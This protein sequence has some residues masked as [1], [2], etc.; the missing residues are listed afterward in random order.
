M[1]TTLYTHPDPSPAEAAMAARV[2]EAAA[3]REPIQIQGNST[4]SGMLQIGRA[5][6]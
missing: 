4:K 5:H 3:S 2:A 6:V 1:D